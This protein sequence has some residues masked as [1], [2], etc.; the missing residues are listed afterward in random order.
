MLSDDRMGW[1]P[2]STALRSVMTGPSDFA[3][4][5]R[6]AIKLLFAVAIFGAGWLLYRSWSQYSFDDILAALRSIPSVHLAFGL[7]FAA[8]SYLCLACNDWLG[9]RYAGR[10][11]P[12]RQT[13]LA[14]FTGLSI[15]HNVGFAALSSGAIRY[16]FYSR[17]GLRAE[18]IA[19]VIL[20]CGTTIALGL[21]TLG[22][23]GL[24]LRPD[25]AARASGLDSGTVSAV[26]ISCLAFPLAYLGLSALVTKP[27]RIRHWQFHP[28]RL[29]LAMGQLAVGTVNVGLVA[30]C[31]HQLLSAIG[32]AGYFKVAAASITANVMA[33][34]SH[35][36]GGLGVLE[37]TVV[38]ALPGAASIAAVVAFRIVY[39]FIPL[40]IGVPL[41][42][43]SEFV[44]RDAAV[45][46]ET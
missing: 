23:V 37:A 43:G 33:I 17:W 28:P 31:L 25:D 27:L 35:V 41:L 36:P 5:L 22:A 12:F 46:T 32:E 42:I 1:E 34:I 9:V 30:A 13:A 19:K 38:H 7:A 40:A 44:L 45:G 18:E 26:A 16:R 2:S 39:Y 11:L 24:W 29:R 15:G 14:S 3:M 4:L 8:G 6:H 20:F 21:A 10:P